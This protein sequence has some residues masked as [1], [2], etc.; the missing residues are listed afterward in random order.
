MSASDGA[1]DVSIAAEPRLRVAPN[2]GVLL[3]GIGLA[4]AFILS[5]PL[6]MILNMHPNAAN[7]MEILKAP[8]NAHLFGTDAQGR[9]VLTRVLIGMRISLAIGAATSLASFVIG[10]PLGILAAASRGSA[11]V[12][13]RLVDTAMSLPGILLALA[14]MAVLGPGL[15]D[16]F[17]V[18]V[19]MWTPL[20]VRMARGAALEVMS[21]DYVQAA[22]ASGASSFAIFRRHLIR[23]A[24]DPVIVQQTI[25]FAGGVLGE[26]TFSFV[27][28]GVQAPNPSLGNILSDAQQNLY[29][30]PW[31]AVIGSMVIVLLVLSIVVLGDG[32]GEL[33]ATDRGQERL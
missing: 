7:P 32:I 17:I 27:G 18:L 29:Q 3:G 22:V 31:P 33:L 4:S 13:M 5:V 12:I 9:D 8:S 24:L 15:T 2:F 11:A 19:A 1:L 23:N 6:P 14:L 26:V 21:Q 16:V 28:A 30:A 10:T 20:T 25:A